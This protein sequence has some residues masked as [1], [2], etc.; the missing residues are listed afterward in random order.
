MLYS[1]VQQGE[2]EFGGIRFSVPL[3]LFPTRLDV[4]GDFMRVGWS[5]EDVGL[6]IPRSEKL[7]LFFDLLSGQP[8]SLYKGLQVSNVGALPTFEK[9]KGCVW[10][11]WTERPRITHPALPSFVSAE[12]LFARLYP[13]RLYVCVSRCPD[14]EVY[15]TEEEAA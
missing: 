1:L 3:E 9:A 2:T 14:V 4:Q 7:N 10:I 6:R 13:D 5:R 15:W 11:N 12:M 8:V